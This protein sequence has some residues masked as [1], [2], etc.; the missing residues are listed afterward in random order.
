MEDTKNEKSNMQ[1][2]LPFLHQTSFLGPKGEVVR[3]QA[4]FDEGA[5]T[6][7]MRASVF[8]HIKHWLGNWHPSMKM[9][10]MANSTII[11]SEAVWKGEVII[12]GICAE[13]EFEVLQSRGGWKFLFGEPMLHAFKAVHGYKVDEVQVLGAEGTRMLQNQSQRK[14]MSIEEVEEPEETHIVAKEEQKRE[15]TIVEE[16]PNTIEQTTLICIITDS[17]PIPENKIGPLLKEVPTDFLANDEA[18][19]TRLTH[20]HNPKCVIWIEKRV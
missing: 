3:V 17:E 16:T 9:L 6:S 18:I 11:K 15:Q 12:G 20:P 2:C 14:K 4:L 5:M 1:H 13:W 8:N 10:Q 19:F 7:D